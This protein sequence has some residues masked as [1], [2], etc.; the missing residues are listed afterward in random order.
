MTGE[1]T[2]GTTGET[3]G[4]MIEGTIEERIGETTETN[5]QGHLR[6]GSTR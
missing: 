5:D 4:G 6:V 2:D 1:M 3:I